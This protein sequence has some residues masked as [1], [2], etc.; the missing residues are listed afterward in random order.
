MHTFKL[1]TIYLLLSISTVVTSSSTQEFDYVIVGGGTAGLAVAA[2]LAEDSERTVLV[3][4]AGTDP[5]TLDS[6]K[7]PGNWTFVVLVWLLML[8]A[9]RF[10]SSELGFS[11]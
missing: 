4:E 6:V 2:R 3:L 8:S 1:A 10:I 5:T 7:I 9:H 11:A